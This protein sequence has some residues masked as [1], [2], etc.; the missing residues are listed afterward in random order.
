ML[1]AVFY[2]S[3]IG[4]LQFSGTVQFSIHVKGMKS[5]STIGKEH[6]RENFK[7]INILL[8]CPGLINFFLSS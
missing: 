7:D 3:L 5:H 2:L 1:R 8:S 4:Q 6:V